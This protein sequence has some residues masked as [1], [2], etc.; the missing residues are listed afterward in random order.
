MRVI[1]RYG[2]VTL[3]WLYFLGLWLILIVGVLSILIIA[4]FYRLSDYRPQI[5]YWASEMLQQPIIIGDIS[6][7]WIDGAPTL[8]LQQIR[9]VSPDKSSFIEV[10]QVRVGLSMLTSLL[11]QQVI[12]SQINLN[13]KQLVLHRQLDGSVR[14]VGFAESETSQQSHEP[15]N[16]DADFL[17]KWL[18]KQQDIHLQIGRVTWQELQRKP[19]HFDEVGLQV[20]KKANNN[21]IMGQVHLPFGDIQQTI[22]FST[23][24]QW[25]DIDL[26]HL[27]GQIQSLPQNTQTLPIFSS[28]IEINPTEQQG[29][30][31]DLS[32]LYIQ[33]SPQ[34]AEANQLNININPNGYQYDID[35]K[36][37]FLELEPMFL[38]SKQI[39]KDMNILEQLRSIA[40]KGRL[41]QI[42]FH[43]PANQPWKLST[44]LDNI[45]F[46]Y[47]QH[48]V[49]ALSG[50]ITAQPDQVN[51]NITHA[52]VDFIEPS[53]Y[54][55]GLYFEDLQTQVQLQKQQ[56]DI[57]ISIN[58][59]KVKEQKTPIDLV[60]KINILAEKQPYL[61]LDAQF[62]KMAAK[63]VYRYIPD[64]EIGKTAEWI[65][66]ALIGG[67]LDS[68]RLQLKGAA[69][70]VFKLEKNQLQF[71][72]QAS[73]VKL[74]YA[75]DW[76]PIEKLNAKLKI[77]KN[78]LII[79]PKQAYL[80]NSPLQ[81]THVIIP[82]LTGKDKKVLISG[83]LNTTATKV[84]KYLYE[85]PLSKKIDLERDKVQITGKVGVNIDLAIGL[86]D[87]PDKIAGFVDFK[88]SRL[89][90]NF[91]GHQVRDLTGRLYFSSDKLYTKQLTGKVWQQ[92]VA[93]DFKL[94][95]QKDKLVIQISAQGEMDRHFINQEM[96][97][98]KPQWKDLKM[99]QRFEGKAAWQAQVDIMNFSRN[100]SKNYTKVQ[101]S[102][103][104]QGMNIYLPAPFNKIAPLK[105]PLDVELLFPR[106]AR[107][108]ITLSLG[109]L[110]NGVLELDDSLYKGQILIGTMAKAQLPKTSRLDVKGHITH[111]GVK[112]WLQFWHN[113]PEGEGDSPLLPIDIQLRL[114]QLGLWTQQLNQVKA[115]LT[116]RES[117]WRIF[118]NSQAMVGQLQY[119]T[120]QDR[121]NAQIK[122]FKMTA[123]Q[124]QY[125]D[126]EPKAL[127]NPFEFP[128][129]SAHIDKLTFSNKELG[130]V[131]LYVK[132]HPKGWEL[133][134]FEAKARGLNIQA[135][136]LWT[137]QPSKANSA[138]EVELHSA[139][140]G[141]L[142][143]R[144]GY[145][146]PPIKQGFT[147]GLLEVQWLGGF[148][149]F[150]LKTMQGHL[151]LLMT[152]GE[153][154]DVD[155]GVGRIF[156][157]FDVL[158]LPKR[159]LLDFRDIT[160]K[161]LRFDSLVGEFDI[162]DGIASTNNVI[163]QSPVAHVEMHG[164]THF[165]EEYYNQTVKIIPHVSNTLPVA[166]TLVGGLGVGAV[167]LIIQK[168]LQSEIEKNLYYEYQV[169]GD[170]DDPQIKL[171]Q[172]D[173]P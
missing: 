9:L 132:P 140:T 163:L 74:N 101:F 30:N 19:L 44:E 39:L 165:V 85:T 129:V 128:E 131:N 4:L 87:Q 20:Q 160:D 162:Q 81:Q 144:L 29:W 80:L 124:K 153:I 123:P 41:S 83:K 48:K 34:N 54:G 84:F 107:D 51:I 69:N 138:L 78:Q 148:D 121:V 36:L 141:E 103:N 154:V 86:D 96:S 10:P 61:D 127:T 33:S 169:M 98:I 108:R 17:L 136:G 99:Y 52:H 120:K 21:H 65:K 14:V 16:A 12:T 66:K 24:S 139:D 119:D 158:I 89:K 106:N 45:Y 151:R 43:Y 93:L 145:P 75:T 135:K 22:Q 143:K 170:W 47:Q 6:G 94:E 79:T 171:I 13:I 37:A 137:Y 150:D 71:D 166:G 122:H 117:L 68:A 57:Q 126:Y 50:Q 146:E 67:Q 161:G 113:L 42:Q 72:A 110:L 70:T 157:L 133:E 112:D 60:G 172:Q 95:E 100:K 25:H 40:T 31:I 92:P 2:L 147:E 59:F 11:Q 49:K 38:L 142:L 149:D 115:T 58:K 63:N 88:N 167:T 109:Q 77:E 53:L 28:Q 168:M 5:E 62:G 90:E 56:Q 26:L 116:H 55:H 76:F 35:A 64:K 130:N 32:Q 102:S 97:T 152:Q 134:L 104:L 114:E 164:H 1:V 7:N 73:Q 125:T 173:N 156:G 8:E 46:K 23:V 159:L 91:I 155:P 15:I 18:L 111:L 82:K 3:R 105:M 118:V 27:N